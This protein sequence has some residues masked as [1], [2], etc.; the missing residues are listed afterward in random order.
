MNEIC[1]LS[2]VALRGWFG[3]GFPWQLIDGC[4]RNIPY[5]SS[6]LRELSNQSLNDYCTHV[7]QLGDMIYYI[8]LNGECGMTR[9]GEVHFVINILNPQTKLLG[10]Y[11]KIEHFEDYV[12]YSGTSGY[13]MVRHTNEFPQCADQVEYFHCAVFINKLIGK[14]FYFCPKLITMR[15]VLSRVDITNKTNM[16]KSEEIKCNESEFSCICESGEYIVVI[17]QE[18][19]VITQEMEV[20]LF[21]HDTLKLCRRF[22]LNLGL[23]WAPQGITSAVGIEYKNRPHIAVSFDGIEIE[24]EIVTHHGICFIAIESA[25]VDEIFYTQ[26]RVEK[27]EWFNEHLIVLS[28]NSLQLWS[29]YKQPPEP[30]KQIDVPPLLKPGKFRSMEFVGT[31]LQVHVGTSLMTYE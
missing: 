4:I 6:H 13:A 12:I 23:T 25:H 22:W 28:Y 7:L 5:D 8:R 21:G 18:V 26:D 14:W 19:A 16:M 3:N 15:W 10:N 1:I 31:Q 17:T 20:F 29:L 9:T 27:L 2:A 30:V 11:H 24:D